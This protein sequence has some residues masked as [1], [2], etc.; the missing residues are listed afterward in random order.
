MIKAAFFDVDGTLLS[1]HTQT[2]RDSA[3]KAIAKLLLEEM[4]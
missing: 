2:V 1:F 4:K 3:K